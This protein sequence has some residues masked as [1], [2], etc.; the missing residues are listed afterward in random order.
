MISMPTTN[1]VLLLVA[2]FFLGLV[3]YDIVDTLILN[4]RVS[5]R[6]NAR[7]NFPIRMIVYGLIAVI[8]AGI[9]IFTLNWVP[10]LILIVGAAMAII[11]LLWYT[12]N[13]GE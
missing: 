13:H 6:L 5:N 12:E 7:R 3:T 9:W 8:G 11:G 1:F 4:D 10:G 2:T